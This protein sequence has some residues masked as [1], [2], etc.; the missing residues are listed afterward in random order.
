MKTVKCFD[1]NTFHFVKEN[2]ENRTVCGKKIK[3]KLVG[4]WGVVKERR[5]TPKK[6]CRVCAGNRR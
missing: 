3:K 5:R 2:N 1:T 4:G 6:M